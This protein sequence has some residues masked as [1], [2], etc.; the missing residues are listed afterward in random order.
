MTAYDGPIF[1]C[2]THI[3]EKNFDFF[4]DYLPSRLHQDWLPAAKVGPDGR[5][6]LFIGDTRVEN[7]DFHPDGLVPP[8]GKLKEWLRA[9]KQGKEIEDGWVPATPDLSE[10]GARL[11][12]L[13]EFGVE[14][15]MLF[16]GNFNA[17]I[18]YLSNDA[19][20]M[21]V[22]RAYNRWLHDHWTF[23]YGNRIYTSGC[24]ALWDT[25]MAIA[26]AEWLIERGVRVVVAPMGPAQGKSLAHPDFDPVWSR[27]NEAGVVLAFHLQEATFM[28]PLIEAWGEKPLQPRMRGQ[29]A[30][31]WMFAFG[32]L[33]AQMTLANIV[34]H[35]FFERFPNIRVASVE[36]G[37]S[38][39]PA[40]LHDLDKNRGIAKNG[41]WPCG[42]LKDRPSTIFK[43]HCC[44]V[45]YPEDPVKQIIEQIGTAKC[46]LMGSDYPHA[47]G[48][49]QP[50]LFA[51]EALDGVSAADARAIMYAN[52]RDL[53][54]AQA[55]RL[56]AA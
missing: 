1:D 10:P 16:V 21:E 23:A 22:L 15:C 42:Q 51:D 5:F 54:P 55:R 41:Y 13:D 24:L 18:G 19:A 34:Y 29:T 47:E 46:L 45:A 52:G 44:V 56:V 12:K 36:N 28:H 49:A 40:F 35:N 27:L 14:A 38:W 26:E 39:L 9:M 31:Q 3:V 37:A 43:E 30:W 11:A 50:R 6:G 17:T 20:G 4:K 8:P 33:P 48:V 25:D 7:Y 32:S 2:D 53:V